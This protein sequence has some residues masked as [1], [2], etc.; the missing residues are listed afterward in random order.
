MQAAHASGTLSP[1]H[2][3]LYFHNP[4]PIFELYDLKADRYQL[5]RLAGKEAF[6][7]IEAAHRNELDRWMVRE[8]DYGP[9]PAHSKKFLD[10][11]Q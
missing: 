4:R 8:G 9:L 7:T 5:N 6:A 1:K 11:E 2:D 10:Q 3:R